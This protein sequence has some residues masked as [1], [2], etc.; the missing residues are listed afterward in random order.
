MGA[1]TMY[2]RQS[3]SFWSQ[4]SGRAIS[5]KSVG[6]RLT[7]IAASV[8]PWSTWVKY[9]PNGL[10]L[11]AG[12]YRRGSD[13]GRPTMQLRQ[14]AVIGVTLGEQSRAFYVDEI[15]ERR[16]VNAEIG[17]HPILV[18]VGPGKTIRVFDRR[19]QATT[20]TFE[21]TGDELTDLETGTLWP[22]LTGV[23]SQGKLNRQSLVRL[24]AVI[25]DDW[26]W[27]SFYPESSFF[28]Q[29]GR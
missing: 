5:G 29:Y 27:R 3:G 10:V 11:R 24:P 16:I 13:A 15:L 7:Q 4:I 20:L 19:L 12:A 17:G 26:A 28:P 1:L 8:E 23:A 25:V 6:R 21:M 18:Y 14:G 22:P 2:D 9:M